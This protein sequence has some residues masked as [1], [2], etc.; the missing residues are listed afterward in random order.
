MTEHGKS[1]TKRKVRKRAKTETHNGFVRKAY[2]EKQ[3]KQEQKRANESAMHHN[4]RM[5]VMQR[6][7]SAYEEN[8]KAWR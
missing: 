1:A 4:E 8:G 5:K 2:V 6:I 7:S 3:E